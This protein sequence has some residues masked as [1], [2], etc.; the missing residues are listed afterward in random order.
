MAESALTTLLRE[1]AS[2]QPNATRIDDAIA[3]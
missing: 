3:S 1:R 2:R